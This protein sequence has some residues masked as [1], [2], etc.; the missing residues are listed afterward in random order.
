MI[1]YNS[2]H[3]EAARGVPPLA[4][5]GEAIEHRIT[6][7]DTGTVLTTGFFL[8]TGMRALCQRIRSRPVSG[9][10]VGG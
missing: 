2:A 7:L 3:G 10:G 6:T 8:T 1:P 5:R 4:S 9:E